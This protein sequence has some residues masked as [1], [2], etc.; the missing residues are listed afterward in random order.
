MNLLGRT[1]WGFQNFEHS[2][3]VGGKILLVADLAEMNEREHFAVHMLPEERVVHAVYLDHAW[4]SVSMDAVKQISKTHFVIYCIDCFVD[5]LTRITHLLRWIWFCC[6][7]ASAHEQVVDVFFTRV[8]TQRGFPSSLITDRDTNT[9]APSGIS[10]ATACRPYNFCQRQTIC[11]RLGK[12]DAQ[13]GS[14]RTLREMISLERARRTHS[15]LQT[16]S[17]SMRFSAGVV[18]CVMLESML[19]WIPTHI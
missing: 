18:T 5:R 11:S 3:L 10:C 4:S 7:L 13:I 12:L 15:P 6:W 19:C 17:P 14:M 9:R 2:Q 16:G 1:L 8:V